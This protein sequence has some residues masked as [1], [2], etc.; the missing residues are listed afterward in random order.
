MLTCLTKSLTNLRVPKPCQ[1]RDGLLVELEEELDLLL[2]IRPLLAPGGHDLVQLLDDRLVGNLSVLVE[3][4]GLFNRA[5]VDVS[6]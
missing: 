1:L 6:S 5:P 3:H 2:A 4:F